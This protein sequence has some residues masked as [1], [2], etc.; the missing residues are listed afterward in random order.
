MLMMCQLARARP[1]LVN[2]MQVGVGLAWS[3]LCLMLPS[4]H[5]GYAA[6]PSAICS[7]QAHADQWCT[8]MLLRAT[9]TTDAP[10]CKATAAPLFCCLPQTSGPGGQEAAVGAVSNLACIR[11]HQQL[12][13]EVSQGMRRV[14]LRLLATWEQRSTWPACTEWHQPPILGAGCMLQCAAFQCAPG[15][16]VE[17]VSIGTRPQ[18]Q[19]QHPATCMYTPPCNLSLTCP[20][21]PCT[22]GR[23]AAA[24]APHAAGHEHG[25]PGGGGPRLWQPSEGQGLCGD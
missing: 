1:M 18:L 5:A 15:K 19:Q 11:S 4:L 13:L 2:M 21:A 8:L 20:A 24:A 23:G 22:G 7:C 16:L 25:V 12:I 10:L 9:C 3:C 17:S 14:Y 6:I